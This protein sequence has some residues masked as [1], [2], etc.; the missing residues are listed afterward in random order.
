MRL[1]YVRWL[2]SRGR[3]KPEGDSELAA[4][5]GVGLPWLNKWKNRAD[6][7]NDRSITNRF[8]RALGVSDAWLIDGDGEPP[9]PQLWGIW[10]EG[11]STPTADAQQVAAPALNE[12]RGRAS[13]KKA[14]KKGS[15][16]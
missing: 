6:A 8:S 2:R 5:T 4:A 14:R 11:A 3:V 10:S 9:R 16:R 1:A 7:P 12:T 15:G 13:A